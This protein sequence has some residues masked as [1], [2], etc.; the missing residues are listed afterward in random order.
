MVVKLVDNRFESVAFSSR[1]ISVQGVS[2]CLTSAILL[3]GRGCLFDVLVLNLSLRSAVR[4]PNCGFAVPGRL[5]IL[6]GVFG[7]VVG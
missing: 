5:V 7:M 2:N 3:R 6:G 1:A 4:Y